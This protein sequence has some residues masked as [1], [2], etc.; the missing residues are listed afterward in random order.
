[1]GMTWA[2]RWRR[3]GI[4]PH[5][6][7]LPSSHSLYPELAQVHPERSREGASCRWFP[8]GGRGFVN[9][10]PFPNFFGFSIYFLAF[11]LC[12]PITRAL[13]I[14]EGVIYLPV[15]SKLASLKTFDYLNLLIPI[16]Y[17]DFSCH[18]ARGNRICSITSS[19]VQGQN[20]S[21]NV[22]FKAGM[23][24]KAGTLFKSWNVVFKS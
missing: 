18:F 11:V 16:F 12:I 20:G 17:R 15:T 9:G 24:L 22:V 14:N 23:L 4:Y 19:L 21:W 1:M 13:W 5:F 10:R 7:L 6:L 3:L 8:T 2:R